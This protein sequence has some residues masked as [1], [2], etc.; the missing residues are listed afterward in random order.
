MRALVLGGLATLLLSGCGTEVVRVGDDD[1]GGASTGGSGSGGSVGSAGA[2][3]PPPPDDG[4]AG[5]GPGFSYAV[6]TLLLGDQ[7]RNGISDKNAWKAYGFNIDGKSSTAASTN[8]CKPNAGGKPSVH[9]DGLDG[10]DNAWGREVVPILVGLEPTIS[11]DLNDAIQSGELSYLFDIPALGPAPSY[12]GL[13]ARYYVGA[14]LASAPLFDGSD[15]WPV[16]AESLLDPNDIASTRWPFAQSYVNDHV[17]VSG[18]APGT[19]LV[20]IG[21]AQLPLELTIHRAVVSA[22]LSSDRQSAG[23]GIIS[24]ILD[25]EELIAEFR[26]FAGTLSPALCEGTSFE[27]I[28]NQWRQSSDILIDGTQD[29]NAVCDG[30]SIGL[31]FEAVRVQLGAIAAPSPPPADPCAR[32]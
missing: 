10:I 8:V 23:G 13:P 17:W 4:I 2:K 27:S 6:Q 12:V 15:L 28:A 30:I 5:D 20:P 3:P 7:D 25:T 14:L 32:P 1:D 16:T 18:S 29:P 11:T 21:L 9:E 31:G 19:L 24:G 22:N 26:K